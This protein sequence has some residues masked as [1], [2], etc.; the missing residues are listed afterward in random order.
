MKRTLLMMLPDSVAV[1]AIGLFSIYHWQ[2]LPL[3]DAAQ[4][5]VATLAAALAGAWL[6]IRMITW[7]VDLRLRGDADV[8]R[9][10]RDDHGR[11]KRE[12]GDG[13]ETSRQTRLLPRRIE[14]IDTADRCS[15][16][17]AT[18]RNGSDGAARKPIRTANP[19]INPV[20]E[21]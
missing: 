13:R 15:G 12:S 9:R 2:L 16:T 14:W 3:S 17:Q 10:A 19:L 8:V 18:M 1:A 20:T 5:T 11:G 4:H 21:S 7:L 6:S